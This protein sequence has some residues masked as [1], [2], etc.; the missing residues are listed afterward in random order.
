MNTEKNE[1]IYLFD[2]LKVI[3]I[4]LVVFGHCIMI[5]LN[6]ITIKV[7]MYIYLFHMPTFVFI[8]GYFFKRRNKK[9][10]SFILKYL[11]FQCLYLL[12]ASIIDKNTNFNISSIFDPYWIMW[13]MYCLI[14]WNI[15]MNIIE[16]KNQKT[17]IILI[18]ISIIMAILAG[19]IE[20]I[21][22]KY[23]LSRMISFFPFFLSGIYCKKFIDIRKIKCSKKVKG[24]FILIFIAIALLTFYLPI[25][26]IYEALYYSEPYSVVGITPAIRLLQYIVGFIFITGFLIIIPNKKYKLSFIGASTEYI[27]LLHGLIIMVLQSMSRNYPSI[28]LIFI[29]DKIKQLIL[30]FILTILIIGVILGV[31]IPFKKL[32][33][34]NNLKN[35]PMN[36]NLTVWRN[37]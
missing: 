35:K 27:Y 8:S 36:S 33:R 21:N 25:A 17:G 34:R 19:T 20:N 13:Y 6:D 4:F 24:I 16:M 31:V 15:I 26:N 11:V 3:L 14:F 28:S 22:T 30:Y 29:Q 37:S 2:N 7:Y 10:L 32:V 1:R 5:F 12:V 23:S 9:V 18:S